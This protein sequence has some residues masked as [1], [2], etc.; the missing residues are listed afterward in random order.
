MTDEDFIRAVEDRGPREALFLVAAALERMA[1]RKADHER[2]IGLREMADV[3]RVA[4]G[5]R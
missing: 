1:N 4:G 2:H 3:L 5:I